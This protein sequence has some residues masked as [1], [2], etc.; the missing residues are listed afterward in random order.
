MAA[1]CYA[2]LLTPRVIWNDLNRHAKLTGI[3]I[4]Q[5]R[6]SFAIRSKSWAK[7]FTAILSS[8]TPDY[9]DIFLVV[10]NILDTHARHVDKGKL[11]L[12][13]RNGSYP[14]RRWMRGGCGVVDHW[15]HWC[16]FEVASGRAPLSK[17]LTLVQTWDLYPR[18]AAVQR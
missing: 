13:R 9:P 5:Y 11:K 16:V 10:E 17:W 12:E 1:N 14:L 4:K 3:S 6:L 7:T 8:T 2:D 18:T 15:W